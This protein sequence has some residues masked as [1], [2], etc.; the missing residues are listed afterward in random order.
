V[1]DQPS[2]SPIRPDRPG[3]AVQRAARARLEV[4]RT[5]GTVGTLGLSVVMALVL[6][7]ALGLWLDRL[8]G[9]SPV[10]FIVGFLLG[11]AAGILNIYRTMSR[12]SK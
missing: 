10:F 3:N 11:L 7:T 1:D 9:W 2:G 6:G 8:T 12:L 5:F 4:A